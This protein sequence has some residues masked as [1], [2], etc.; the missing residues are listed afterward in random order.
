MVQMQMCKKIKKKCK[1]NK[2][3]LL[4]IA[5]QSFINYFIVLF[6]NA[7]NASIFGIIGTI[8]VFTMFNLIINKN[9]DEPKTYSIKKWNVWNS[10][11]LISVSL[12]MIL[13][14]LVV[15]KNDSRTELLKINWS[16]IFSL[17][18]FISL[19]IMLLFYFLPLVGL[20]YWL[21]DSKENSETKRKLQRIKEKIK[22]KLKRNKKSPTDHN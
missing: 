6:I 4:L 12:N 16:E 21:I 1:R 3:L 9:D 7:R 17:E 20:F 11:S 15:E 5:I 19:A 8:V 18:G 13:Y 10:C 2:P 14:Y 22:R